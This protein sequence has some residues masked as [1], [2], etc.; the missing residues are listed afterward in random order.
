MT[1]TIS[2]KPQPLLAL[3]A[4]TASLSMALGCRDGGDGR[5][6]TTARN[7]PPTQPATGGHPGKGGPGLPISPAT[8]ATATATAATA[9]G[10][11]TV[12]VA[13][14][15]TSP[16][17]WHDDPSIEPL[18]AVATLEQRFAAPAGFARVDVA[19]D[20]FGAWLRRLPLAAPGSPVLAYDGRLLLPGDH[21][22]LASVTTLDIGNRDLQQC[23]D[24]IMRLHGEW[25]WH[26]KR[27][28]EASYPSGGGPIPWTRY[29]S[30][31][32]PKVVGNTFEWRSGR[33]RAD[34]HKTYRRYFDVVAGWA[35]T[36]S[37]ARSAKQ[38]SRDAVRP[39]DFFVLPGG[40]GHAVLI[41]DL[42]RS[43]DG[44]LVALMGQSFM[45][46]QNFQVLRPSPRTT[47]FELDPKQG[48]E[49]PFW[50]TFPWSSLRRLD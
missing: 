31:Q 23:A 9:K 43:A 2:W 18:E 39:G 30:G 38:P 44:R 47:W 5:P 46:A 36:V 26:H 12:A 40:P 49:T 13:P 15:D 37:L 3:L 50:D 27:A 29:L 6:V 42:A 8:S 25:L 21:R 28:K 19:P 11:A 32:Y 16:Y 24:A 45:P 1:P 7:A 48:V 35:N 17:A 41:L 14:L 20:S 4:V 10:T 22:N 34:S 33:P